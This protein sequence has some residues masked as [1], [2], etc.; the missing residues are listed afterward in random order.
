MHIGK[1]EVR[2]TNRILSC[3]GNMKDTW[4]TI[5]ELC[6]KKSKSS[7]IDGLRETDAKIV[8]KNDIANTMNSFFCSIGQNLA[9][10]IDPV[11]NPILSGDYEVN[12]NHAKFSFMPIKVKMIRDAVA[13]V[14]TAKSSGIDNISSYFLKLALPFIENSLTFLF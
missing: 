13:K 14:M 10:K 5:N 9:S 6:S 12:K 1:Y 11:P 7:N 4:R 2:H 3:K 8:Q